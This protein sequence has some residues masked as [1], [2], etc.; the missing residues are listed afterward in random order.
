MQINEK[1]YAG[2]EKP[3][4]IYIVAIADSVTIQASD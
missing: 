1:S 3:N 2:E 4:F